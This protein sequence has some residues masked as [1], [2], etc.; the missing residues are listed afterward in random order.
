MV[1]SS[2]VLS[3]GAGATVN[4]MFPLCEREP[5]VASTV[6][7]V[8]V[9]V[10]EA[11]TLKV[12]VWLAPAETEK[13]DAGEG[14][15]PGGI[16]CNRNW[17]TLLNS[18]FAITAME[19]GVVV[20][21]TPMDIEEGEIERLKS[22]AGG[23]V[24]GAPLLPQAIRKRVA[25]SNENSRNPLLAVLWRVLLTECVARITMLRLSVNLIALLTGITAGPRL[26]QLVN[27]S[28]A[29]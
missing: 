4:S 16:F 20:P 8:V 15:I 28:H 19:T 25:A 3:V 22:E 2:K 12:I 29:A 14:A 18:F 27:A 7:D 9:G 23:A 21:P 5:L 1:P 11:E 17:T 26:Q 10:A 6:K 24:G 13:G